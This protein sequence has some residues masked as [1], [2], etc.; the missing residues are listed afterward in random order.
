MIDFSGRFLPNVH[1]QEHL[2]YIIFNHSRAITHGYLL[3]IHAFLLH[4]EKERLFGHYN[5]S[6]K[7]HCGP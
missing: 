5:I 6:Y 1:L 2:I 3:V 4:V 7:T